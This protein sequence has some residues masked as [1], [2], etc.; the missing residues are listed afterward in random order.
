MARSVKQK[1]ARRDRGDGSI[2]QRANGMWCGTYSAGYASDGSRKRRTVFGESREDVQKKLR[3]KL[4]QATTSLSVAPT[5]VKLGDYLGRWLNDAAKSAVRPTTY[6]NYERVIKN[7]IKPHLGGVALGILTPVHVQSMIAAL[8]RDGKSAETI[9]LTYAV[10]RRA[11]KQAVTWGLLTHNATYGVERPRAVKMEISV[12]DA[13]QVAK[14]LSAAKDDRLEALYVLAVGAGMRLGE[15]FGLQWA[16]VDLA[17][18]TI[19]VRRTLSELNGKLFPSEPKTAKGRRKIDLPAIVVAALQR[20]RKQAMAEG[21]AAVEWVFCNS[22]G[23]PLRRSRFHSQHFKPLLRK[24]GLPD[25]RFHDLRHTSATLLLAAG[26]HPK[27]VQERLGHSQISVTL[28]TYSH[29]L[30]SMQLD[31]A[32]RLDALMTTPSLKAKAK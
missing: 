5:K 18:R 8:K 23:T 14:L 2:Y 30:P 26:V 17:A 27:V 24:A 19:M 4:N 6:S 3:D 28:D 7:H 15:I 1:R 29:I 11:L 22:I 16:D 25:I 13:E 21:F 20:H 10:L 12:Y 9:R 32:T 31:A